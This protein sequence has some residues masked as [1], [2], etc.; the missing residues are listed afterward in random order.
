LPDAVRYKQIKSVAHNY[1]H[2]FVS[3]MNYVGDDF[4]IG[5]LARA[6]AASRESELRVDLLTGDAEPA[7]L[8][9]PPVRSSLEWYVPWLDGLLRSHGVEIDALREAAMRVRFDLSRLDAPGLTRAMVPYECEVEI[10][11][12]RGI[13][14]VGTVRDTWPVDRGESTTSLP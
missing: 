3:A 14:H 11:D 13:V 2:S 9:M 8:L 6:A 5:H 7:A 1:A 4:V 10:T 12:D